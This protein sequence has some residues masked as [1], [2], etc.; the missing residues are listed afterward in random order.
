[1]LE[2]RWILSV[3]FLFHIFFRVI[4]IDFE[5][6]SCSLDVTGRG[7][8]EIGQVAGCLELT[9]VRTETCQNQHAS[10]VLQKD[11]LVF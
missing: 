11:A 1:M 10:V 9:V 3:F 5:F 7:K 6:D 4:T 2:K 8:K